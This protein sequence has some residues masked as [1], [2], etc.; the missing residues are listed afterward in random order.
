MAI[1]ERNIVQIRQGKWDA[2]VEFR[3]KFRAL[4]ERHGFPP[5]TIY[6]YE[7]G[8]QPTNTLVGEYLWESFSEKEEKVAKFWADPDSEGLGD[9]FEASVECWHVEYLTKTET[10]V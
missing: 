7:S 8:L 1:L 6:R 4:E 3:K 9:E 2:F 10:I 5:A